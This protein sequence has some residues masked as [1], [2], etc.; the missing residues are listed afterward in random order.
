MKYEVISKIQ[1]RM[2]PYLNQGAYL[3]LNKVLMEVFMEIEIIG[4]NKTVD[5]DNYELL[6]VFLS[7]KKIEGCSNR[8]IAY[9]GKIIKRLFLKLD[10]GVEDIS[11]EDLRD[12]LTEYRETGSVSK[13]TVDNVRRVFSSFFHG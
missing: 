7:A 13:T 9:Y 6:D 2:R 12:Y 10:K 11:T 3:R 5:L 1:S 4:N 8:T